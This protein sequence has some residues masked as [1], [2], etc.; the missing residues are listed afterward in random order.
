MF[1][2]RTHSDRAARSDFFLVG[3]NLAFADGPTV[4][5]DLATGRHPSAGLESVGK[6][7]PSVPFDYMLVADNAKQMAARWAAQIRETLREP[8]CAA[9]TLAVDRADTRMVRALDAADF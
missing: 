1:L 9:D 6:V 8:G 4:L 3:V 5:L 7:R 2:D